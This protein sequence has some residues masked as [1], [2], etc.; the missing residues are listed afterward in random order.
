MYMICIGREGLVLSNTI[1]NFMEIVML[2]SVR[3]KTSLNP[4]LP[5]NI[6]NFVIIY[7]FRYTVTVSAHNNVS[8]S[9]S[10]A[11][12]LH[13]LSKI[14]SLELNMMGSP[15]VN[16]VLIFKA[17]FYR[18]S[19][20]RFKWNFGDGSPVVMNNSS[21]YM[22]HNFTKYVDVNFMLQSLP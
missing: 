3:D 19:E 6:F 15:I 21:Q 11:V 13:L 16:N 22:E 7:Y 8:S 20:I 5:N 2:M 18:G 1:K 14:E 10:P 12:V 17:T 9:T 4:P